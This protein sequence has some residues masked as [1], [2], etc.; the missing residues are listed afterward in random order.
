MGFAAIARVT[1]NRWVTCSTR[2]DISFGLKPGDELKVET[3][4]CHEVRQCNQAVIIDHVEKDEVY[5][6]H[7]TPAMYGF[8]S[9]I[10][11]PIYRR[12][13][14]FFGTLCAI[15]PKPAQLNNP[16][17][18]GMFTLFAD[19]ISFHLHTIEQLES[20]ETKLTEELETAELRDKFLAIL[21]HDLRNPLGTTKLSVEALLEK[22]LDEKARRLASIIKNASYRMSGLVD[23]ILD[24]ARGRFGGGI[25]LEFKHNDSLEEVITQLVAENQAMSSERVIETH[26]DLK[27]AV[28][29]DSDR[30]AQLFS[31]ILGNAIAHGE[32]DQPIRVKAI[33]GEGEFL[34]SVTNSGDKIPLV[35][36]DR[37]FQPFSR[38]DGRPGKKGLGLGLYI[39]SEIARAHGGSLEADSSDQQTCFTFRMPTK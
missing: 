33:S 14:G 32:A 36:M 37:L 27:E 2:D 4:I 22:P 17:T 24:Y 34:L 15:D 6:R 23:S 20:T 19:L 10:S 35:V 9:Y 7:H 8:Q 11:V 3:T 38:E 13:G 5:A 26:Y 1:E 30:V 29:C 31:N 28:L 18:I 21:A 39:A 25:P 12:D 16:E